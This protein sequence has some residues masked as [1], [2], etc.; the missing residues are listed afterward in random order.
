[1]G[2][3][4][5]LIF[6]TYL[7]YLNGNDS[8]MAILLILPFLAIVDLDP[9]LREVVCHMSS[10]P[11]KSSDNANLDPTIKLIQINSIQSTSQICIYIYLIVRRI[12]NFHDH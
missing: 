7:N 4:V 9:S 2:D 10:L 3:F 1:M 8:K 6:F 5:V 11:Q 12:S